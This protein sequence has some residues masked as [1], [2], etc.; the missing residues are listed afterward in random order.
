M[1][2]YI[3]EGLSA[4]LENNPIAWHMPGHKRKN[5][6]TKQIS[7]VDRVLETLYTTDVTEVPGTDDL[8]EPEGMILDS[9]NELKKVYG[10]KYSSYMVNGATGGI[11]SAIYAAKNA[12][13]GDAIGKLLIAKNC[14]KSVYNCADFLKLNAV[15]VEPEEYFLDD[16]DKAM[17]KGHISPK[18][19]EEICN[20]ENVFAMVLSSP[21]YEGVVS[22]IK[23]IADILHRNGGI[24]IVDEAHGAHLPFMSRYGF[25]ESAISCGA[26]IVVQSLH[27]TLPAMTQS[28][29]I[30]VNN[31]RLVAYVKEALQIF[32][33]SSPSYPMMCSMESA[34]AWACDYDYT[35][36][37]NLLEDFRLSTESYKIV[38]VLSEEDSKNEG[39][40]AYDR[41]RIVITTK[42]HD[43][44]GTILADYLKKEYNLLVEMI[45]KNY[46]VLISTAADNSQDFEMLKGALDALDK[47][48]YENYDEMG[49]GFTADMVVADDYGNSVIDM[50]KNLK[51]TKAEN[52]LYVYPPG[53]YIVRRGEL[54]TDKHVAELAGYARAGLNIRGL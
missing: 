4:F 19:V 20:R 43:I 37:N 28:A 39:A 31:E 16:N 33:S 18:G 36:Y 30:H 51:G 15:F 7:C 49:E 10:T 24:L 1:R 14:H 53:S 29:I 46:L 45:G 12:I 41:S 48:L 26:D 52:N 34:I 50:I 25:P 54:I 38:E 23:S 8:H 3:N 6:F 22:D 32:M 35:E 9:L 40:F 5:G 11:Q 44:P 47:Y 2:R 21:S 27:K 42:G 17:F 13:N